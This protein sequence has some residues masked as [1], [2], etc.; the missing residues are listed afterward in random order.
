[1][2]RYLSLIHQFPCLEFS[3]VISFYNKDSIDEPF[4][5]SHFILQSIMKKQLQLIT[6]NTSTIITPYHNTPQNYITSLFYFYNKLS[7]IL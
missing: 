3:V 1:M 7:F 6:L 2:L 5:V 4:L